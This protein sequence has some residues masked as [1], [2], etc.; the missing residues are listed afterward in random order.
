[1]P[2]VLQLEDGSNI[3]IDTEPFGNGG[4]GDVFKILSPSH[5]TNQVVKLY[6]K[7]RLTNEA[8]NKIKYLVSKRINQ[9]EHESIV[10]IK[11]IVLDNGRFVGFTMNYADGVG[12]EKF[13]LNRWWQKNNSVDW[14]KFRLEN[15]KGS[16]NRI[17]LCL[18]I[19]ISI[20]IIHKSGNYT[21]TDIKPSNF[22]IQ[23]NGLV[24]IIDIDNI[25]VVENG[26]ILYAAQLNT[27]E[28]SPPEFH[29]GL[30]YK[31][32]SA[33]QNWDRY[34]LSILFYQLLCG[35]HPFQFVK[36]KLREEEYTDSRM[37]AEG[38]FL[39][40]NKSN[41]LEPVKPQHKN[42]LNLN[43]EIKSLFFQCFDKGHSNP[44]LRP[45]VQDWCRV[46]ANKTLVAKRL[47]IAELING[48]TTYNPKLKSALQFNR[49]SSSLTLK[50][51]SEIASPEIKF[52][53]FSNKISILD[54][55]V[56]IFTK[57]QKQV[58]IEQLKEIEVAI[59][60]IIHKQ[61]DIKNEITKI[62][63]E[64]ENKQLE[65]KSE[66]K[67]Q[68]D[69]LKKLLQLALYDAEYLAT[70]AHG[71][72]SKEIYE[73]KTQI[74]FLVKKEGDVLAEYHSS[75]F[76]DLIKNIEQKRAGYNAT[77]HNYEID[78]RKDIERL[79]N[80]PNKLSNYNLEKECSKIFNCNLPSLITT[81]KNLNFFTAA[82]FK[83]AYSN[84]Y[85]QNN[86][87]ID[88]RIPGMGKER[89]AKLRYWRITIDKNEN[90]KIIKEVNS[91]YNTL[92]NKISL[93]WKDF[94]NNHNRDIAPLN[95]RFKNKEEEINQNKAKL[96]DTRESEIK[97]VI[98]KF[99]KLHIELKNNFI[100][101]LNQFYIDI[102]NIYQKTKS[103][104]LN[105]FTF[106]EGQLK[107]KQSEIK[108]SN[109]GIEFGLAKY[110]ALYLKII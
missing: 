74:N 76:G 87:N 31:K 13:F 23:K 45:S 63:S 100:K 44:Q 3:T 82:D 88:V 26:K 77:M 81:L 68:I 84:G 12:L 29:N 11:N 75:I 16:E 15:E 5:L 2:R 43:N 86:L 39:F 92:Q 56:N 109:Q 4:S 34:S 97:K 62:F 102:E 52:H 49:Y 48:D 47:S 41:H 46:F 58:L 91:R 37:I 93:D 40:G 69:K 85:L 73:L 27:S 89:S 106:Y 83:K 101:C 79:I 25:E 22:K 7:E 105:N 66:E 71:E 9:G 51:N 14:D 21:I 61:S 108:E 36:Y 60:D 32:S 80:S 78:K 28:Y 72:E 24:S 53:N 59:T 10:W 64:F 65:I 38:L 99:D 55:V 33:S 30:D 70:K 94:E 96:T 90:E 67:L 98:L 20:N 103:D 8:E 50:S 42:F 35:I 57:S 110:N 17:R 107:S 6:H 1:M 54:K 95:V 18:N 19:A 104:L